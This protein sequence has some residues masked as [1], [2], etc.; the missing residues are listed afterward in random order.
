MTLK[1]PKG[2]ELPPILLNLNVPLGPR[3][4]KGKEGAWFSEQ[5]HPFRNLLTGRI[6]EFALVGGKGYLSTGAEGPS[7][8]SG[9]T[10]ASTS[11]KI[12]AGI[13]G[14]SRN[15]FTEGKPTKARPLIV[16]MP[17]LKGSKSLFDTKAL[18]KSRPSKGPD[19]GVLGSSVNIFDVKP[20]RRRR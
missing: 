6:E 11:P 20:K 10:K 13:L 9:S 1:Q 14:S 18:S 8:S 7:K 4:P 16:E 2:D 12:D 5:R 3:A 17:T 15:V 19:V